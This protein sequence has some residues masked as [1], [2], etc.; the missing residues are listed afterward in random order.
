MGSMSKWEVWLDLLYPTL[1]SG[2]FKFHQFFPRNN[3]P[4]LFTLLLLRPALHWALI[5]LFRCLCVYSV[6]SVVSDSLWPSEPQPAR[7][8]CPWESPGKNTGV[9]CHALLQGIVP[10]QGSNLRL[11][12]L[13]P[14]QLGSLPRASLCSGARVYL[15]LHITHRMVSIS[16]L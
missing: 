12:H 2:G 4:F 15:F 7:L 6:A 13:L 5:F 16:F 10:T 3:C 14:W 1:E 11:L 8:L 9:G